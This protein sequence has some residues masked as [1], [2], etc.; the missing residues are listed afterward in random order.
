MQLLGLLPLLLPVLLLLLLALLPLA[1]GSVLQ[2]LG[3]NAGL[4]LRLGVLLGPGSLLGLLQDG[5]LCSLL[6]EDLLLQKHLLVGGS[7]ELG[8]GWGGLVVPD[9]AKH[10]VRKARH[11]QWGHGSLCKDDY[12]CGKELFS[13]AKHAPVTIWGCSVHTQDPFQPP[14]QNYPACASCVMNWGAWANRSVPVSRNGEGVQL[15]KGGGQLTYFFQHLH[16]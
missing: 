7:A 1:V 5:L 14:R 15:T 12:E 16:S 3:L 10:A 11:L 8:G 2:L 9:H 6:G 4:G 13:T